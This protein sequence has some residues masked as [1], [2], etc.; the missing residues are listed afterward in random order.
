MASQKLHSLLLIGI[1]CLALVNKSNAECCTSKEEVIFKMDRGDCE[2]VGGH[3]DDPHRCRIL[4]CA[5]GVGLHGAYCGRGPCNVFG[6]NCD[7][8]CLT[9]DW[10]RSFVQNNRYNGIE[11]LEVTRIP[12]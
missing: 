12:L 11:I 3:G 10:S 2:D 4:I 9:G 7:G 1:C 8:G 6:C 5:D